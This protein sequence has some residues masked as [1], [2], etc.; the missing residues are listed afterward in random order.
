MGNKIKVLDR[1]GRLHMHVLIL[2]FHLHVWTHC[3]TLKSNLARRGQL[4]DD[5][6]FRE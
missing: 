3:H 2:L 5:V 6:C 4:R 1:M